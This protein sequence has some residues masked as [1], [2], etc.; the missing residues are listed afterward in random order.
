[1]RHNRLHGKN[2]QNIK[3]S[4]A[5]TAMVLHPTLLRKGCGLYEFLCQ[6]FSWQKIHCPLLRDHLK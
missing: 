5:T 3:L 1:M 6:D 4:T 2:A